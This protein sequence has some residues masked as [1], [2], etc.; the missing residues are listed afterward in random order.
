MHYPQCNGTG[1]DLSLTDLDREGA[2]A[3]YGAPGSDPNP[4]P[5]P[6]PDPDPDPQPD[7]DPDPQPDPDPEPGPGVPTNETATGSVAQDE[8]AEFEPITVVSGTEFIVNMTGTGDPDLYVQFGAAPD[9]QSFDCRPFVE[10][11]DEQCVLTVPEG[12]TQ[13]FI[14]VHGFTDGDFDLSVDFFAPE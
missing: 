13:A 8:L 14:M 12:E 10:G 4:D 3:L 2:T 1:T 11:P 6:E 5:D 7:P 9:L